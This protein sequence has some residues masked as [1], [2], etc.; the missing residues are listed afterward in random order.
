MTRQW[1]R[2]DF[3]VLA[4]GILSVGLV[5]WYD[6]DGL[7]AQQRLAIL[8]LDALLVAYFV[9]DWV[10]MW[11]D[12]QWKRQWL[13]WNT[14]RLLGMLPLF[15][16]GFAF[17]RL[18]RLARVVSVLEKIPLFR[19]GLRS[20]KQNL[21]WSSLA[22]LAIAAASITFVGALLVWLAERGSNPVF[23]EF[24]EAIWWAI[25]TVTTVG[26]GDITPITRIGRLVAVLLMVTGIG[27]I[28]ML[29]SQVSAAMVRREEDV[30][31]EEAIASA[32]PTSVA[33]QLS[34]LAALHDAGKLTDDEFARAKATFLRG[35]GV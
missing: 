15:I 24:S 30:I 33:G 4:L 1:W 12:R 26:Y 35:D 16:T 7:N 9:L 31:E 29:A 2:N 5:Y 34:Q 19:K 8:A 23:I 25:V 17:L 14:W 10:M 27:T 22:P 18:L 21:D 6:T 32:A 11:R 28:G 3:L 20:L 13:F